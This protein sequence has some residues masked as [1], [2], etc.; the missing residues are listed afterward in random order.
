MILPYE[1]SRIG[2]SIEA[3]G[4][5]VCALK[6]GWGEN[7][8]WLLM[9]LGVFCGGGG[10]NDKN[11]LELDSSDAYTTLNIQHWIL[12]CTIANFM[13]HE[14]HLTFKFFKFLIKKQLEIFKNITYV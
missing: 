13:L 4:S 6:W 11:T 9:G 5:L 10:G 12:Y 1:M 2:K 8:E 3:E 14:L 7:G